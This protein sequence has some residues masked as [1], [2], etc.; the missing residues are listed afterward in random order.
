VRISTL[1]VPGIGL[2]RKSRA[3][4]Y[5]HSRNKAQPT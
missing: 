1:V 4:P 3:L 2:V 5:Q